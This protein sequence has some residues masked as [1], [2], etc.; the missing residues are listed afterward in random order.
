MYKYGCVVHCTTQHHVTRVHVA[1]RQR[2]R[3]RDREKEIEREKGWV[4]VS[5]CREQGRGSPENL[6]SAPRYKRSISDMK[7]GQIRVETLNKPM[8]WS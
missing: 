5:A 6:K 1:E 4:A 3:A 8:Y 7:S 2:E